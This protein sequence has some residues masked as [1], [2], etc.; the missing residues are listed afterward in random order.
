MFS[1]L[2][3][4]SALADQMSTKTLAA[5]CLATI[6][7]TSCGVGKSPVGVS[8]VS[9]SPAAAFAPL[10]NEQ[11]ERKSL[12]TITFSRWKDAIL[13]DAAVGRNPDGT[14][15]FAS[16][17][18]NDVSTKR[19]PVQVFW[20]VFDPASEIRNGAE[21]SGHYSDSDSLKAQQ[22]TKQDGT[23]GLGFSYLSERNEAFFNL[24]P[25]EYEN[26]GK[27]LKTVLSITTHKAALRV[28]VT[29]ENQKCGT[30]TEVC[31]GGDECYASGTFAPMGNF[32]V[33]QN[34]I[35]VPLDVTHTPQVG[36]NR[37]N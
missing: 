10:V 27:S 37:A 14:C 17:K 7:L 6:V 13:I 32:E 16:Q 36:V 28:Y 35:G 1:T 18:K 2:K 25:I 21:M 26:D 15:A 29:D 19:M 11:A 20:V 22:L 30:R 33:K 12:L 31:D 24:T 23:A 4:A 34:M 8:H 9:D 3:K 5:V